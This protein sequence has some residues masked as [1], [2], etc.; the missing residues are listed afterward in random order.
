MGAAE[1]VDA[2]KSYVVWYDQMERDRKRSRDEAGV[3]VGGVSIGC[4]RSFG[5]EGVAGTIAD[6]GECDWFAHRREVAIG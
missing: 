5:G 1:G 6:G 2:T 3:M 4:G